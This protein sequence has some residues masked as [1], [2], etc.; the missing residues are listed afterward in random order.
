M[1]IVIHDLKRQG[2]S[3]SA[4]ARRTGLDRTLR[5]MAWDDPRCTGPLAAAAA[6]WEVGTGTGI[7]IS[8][9][10][11]TAFNDQPLHELSP[12]CDVMIIDF[13]H[14]SQA[15][16]EGAVIPIES[17]VGDEVT[18]SVSAN[19]IGPAQASFLVNGVNAAFCS[20]A[21]CHVAAHRPAVLSGCGAPETWDGVMSL[22]AEF[23]GSV[24]LA[25][26]PTD[27]V[28]SLMSIA[29][30]RG[31]A[32]DGGE[33]FFPDPGAAEQSIDLLAGL[34][35]AVGDYCWRCTP[36]ALFRAARTIPEIACTPLTFGYTRFTRPEEGGWRFTAPPAGCGSTL[37]GAGMAVSSRS[38]SVK[39]A[40]E[41]VSWYCGDEGQLLAA[42]A[43]GQP[44]GLSA[45]NDPGIDRMTSGFYSGTR[46]TQ[47][48][49]WVRPLNSWWPVV[50]ERVGGQLVRMLLAGE[51][52]HRIL[53][54]IEA[55]YQSLRDRL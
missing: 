20:D 4:I 27:A 2:L 36:Q 5:V 29:A 11:L 6:E 46:A 54:G 44:A 42:R 1:I 19:A 25:L 24:A 55:L 9:R 17:I 41:F 22:A 39:S 31:A 33:R 16:R 18:R 7:E 14:V 10:P 28:V 53:S 12:L 37:G 45:W 49:A 21:A 30:G 50:Q 13:P 51:P 35:R 15:V 38:E 32:P 52:A 40:A 43:W 23:P 48:N 47:A 34:A 3:I 8:R 26:Y